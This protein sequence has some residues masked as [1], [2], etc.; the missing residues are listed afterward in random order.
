MSLP[1]LQDHPDGTLLLIQATPRARVTSAEGLQGDRLR[2]RVASPPVDGKAND[3]VRDWAGKTFGCRPRSIEIVRGEKSRQKDLLLTGID[4]ATATA[5]LE[6]L[7]I[8]TSPP[9][10]ETNK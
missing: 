8:A 9:Q 4:L 7:G 3:A 10:S 5:C 1:C 2:L 6:Q